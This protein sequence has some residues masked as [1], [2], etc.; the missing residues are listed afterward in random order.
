M[1]G[2]LIKILIVELV[3]IILLVVAISFDSFPSIDT[4]KDFGHVEDYISNL[5]KNESNYIKSKT[6][7]DEDLIETIR[8]G[9]LEG[10]ESISIPRELLN[11]NMDIFF[12]I[13]K[14]VL[15][16]TPEIC[17]ILVAILK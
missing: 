16:D 17:I 13:V 2:K 6:N 10:H 4:I 8:N 12:D 3:I 15:L 5:D 11:D 14:K 9:L 7:E 1:M